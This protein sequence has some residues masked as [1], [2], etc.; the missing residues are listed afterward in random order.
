[1]SLF[2]S[3]ILHSFLLPCFPLRLFFSFGNRERVAGGYDL[4]GTGGQRHQTAVLGKN[5]C[6][7]SKVWLS[8]LS[9]GRT[10]HLVDH[11]SGL[12]HQR[13]SRNLL[14]YS[15]L[16]SLVTKQPDGIN[17]WL[18]ILLWW[19]KTTLKGTLVLVRDRYDRPSRMRIVLHDPLSV[20]ETLEPPVYLSYLARKHSVI[21]LDNPQNSNL[22]LHT[23]Q[24][25]TKSLLHLK[26][27]KTPNLSSQSHHK[28]SD[29]IQFLWNFTYELQKPFSFYQN[30]RES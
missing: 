11:N 22:I 14:K 2:R 21:S 16:Y 28:R 27:R 18:T 19:L 17:L 1:M 6:V 3:T 29:C 5:G 8:V 13:D 4:M 10:Q 9:W 12:L 7:S 23:Q 26:Y 20:F 30:K 25:N 15:W 24:C